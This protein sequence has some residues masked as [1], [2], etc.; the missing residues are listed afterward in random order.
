MAFYQMKN[1]PSIK[2]G[3]VK[4]LLTTDEEIGKGVAK[5]DLKLFRI[6]KN[7]K[8]NVKSLR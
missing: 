5:V 2:H 6:K 8:K 4:M 3:E 1:N 7:I